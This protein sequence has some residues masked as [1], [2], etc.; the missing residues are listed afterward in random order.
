ME[1]ENNQTKKRECEDFSRDEEDVE[2]Q[3][4]LDD[5]AIFTKADTV[6]VKERRRSK[7]GEVV[8]VRRRDTRSFS[9]VSSGG[10][11]LS[12]TLTK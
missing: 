6:K 4:S 3:C 7:K 10:I 9:S 2:S 1:T 11:R 12:N 8:S 5:E